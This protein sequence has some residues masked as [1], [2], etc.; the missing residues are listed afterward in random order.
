MGCHLN[1]ICFLLHARKCNFTDLLSYKT[2]SFQTPFPKPAIFPLRPHIFTVPSTYQ[3]ELRET[4]ILIFRQSPVN[5]A[6][7]FYMER[8]KAKQLAVSHY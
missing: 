6:E 1:E 7:Y 2:H 5:A 8:S 3:S 4:M